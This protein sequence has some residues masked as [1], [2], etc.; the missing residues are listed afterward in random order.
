MSKIIVTGG[1]GFI[2]THLVKKLTSLG[3]EVK[4]YDIVLDPKLDVRDLESTKRFFEGAEFVFHLAAIV[5]V[6]YS[7]ENIAETNHTNLVGTL[8]V[9]IS[10]KE[11]EVKRVI[12]SSSAAVYGDQEILP[13]K[14][15]AELRPKS[16][17]ALQKLESEMY[18]KLFADI[19]EL[20]TVSLRYF[21]VY[22]EGQNP[23]GPY[24]SAI[25][26]FIE[27]K[28]NNKSI[29]I[30]GDGKQTRDFINV[31]DVVSANISAMESNEIGKGESINIATG[32]AVSI[33]S[34]AALVGGPI[35]HIP[36]RLEI[37]DSLADISLAKSLLNW[38]PKVTLEE[39]MVAML[40]LLN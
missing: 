6:P 28:K 11:A 4:I 14:E 40:R 19:Y 8:N 3:H 36:P 22:G 13:V 24:A 27:Q 31:A 35:E 9:L 29:T 37:K 18:L 17:Y 30:I 16:P 1:A 33:N 26:K 25:P 7:I 23:N 39:G 20:Q 21:N 10:A 38:A 12:L 2:G 32:I 34:V 15:N 5:S